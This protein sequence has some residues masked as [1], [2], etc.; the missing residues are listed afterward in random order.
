MRISILSLATTLAT[1]LLAGALL[2]GPLLAGGCKPKSH[3]PGAGASAGPAS[4]A[5]PLPQQESQPSGKTAPP[6]SPEAMKGALPAGHPPLDGTSAP[7]EANQ[8][9]PSP[10]GKGGALPPGHP[11]MGSGGMVPDAPAATGGAALRY[12][13]PASWKSQKP[14]SSMRK[15]QFAIPGPGGDAE[16]IVF[17]FPGTGGDTA[18]NLTRWHAQ[19]TQPDGKSSTS[20]AKNESRTVNTLKVS[21]TTLTGN[22]LKPKDPMSMNGPTENLTNQG[23][24]GAIVEAAGGPWFFKA[25][26]PAAT[27]TANTAAFEELVKSFAQ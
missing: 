9:A 21:I 2:A 18:S 12:T 22:F 17:H 19:F 13:A 11:A 1:T 5:N 26:G 8:A 3:E 16:L 24:W 10:A 4:S 25:V 20:V 23:L 27:L 14:A 6:L 7:Q 15:A